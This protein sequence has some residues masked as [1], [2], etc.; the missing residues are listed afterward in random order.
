[1]QC[2]GFL[3]RSASIARLACSTI[4]S[5]T[6][7]PEI[8]VSGIGMRLRL[9]TPLYQLHQA[10]CLI[11]TV[12]ALLPGPYNRALSLALDF[13]IHGMRLYNYFRTTQCLIHRLL[14]PGHMT[15]DDG[16]EIRFFSK[17]G[18]A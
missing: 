15:Q 14:P 11:G 5:G 8:G 7:V 13:G 16:K 12:R 6:T 9:T 3:V 10:A 1:M 4:A 2:A 18:L 17:K